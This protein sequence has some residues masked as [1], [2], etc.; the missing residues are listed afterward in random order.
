MAA[1]G[2]SIDTFS[3]GDNR[4]VLTLAVLLAVVTVVG[5]SCFLPAARPPG[6]LESF[7]LFESEDPANDDAVAE[8]GR[9]FTRIVSAK[10]NIWLFSDLN[11]DAGKSLP[12]NVATG[13]D[14]TEEIVKP[15]VAKLRSFLHDE[16]FRIPGA[17]N[18]D[19]DKL[20]QRVVALTSVAPGFDL[21]MRHQVPPMM[22][23][24]KYLLLISKTGQVRVAWYAFVSEKPMPG[25]ESGAFV[26]KMVSEDLNTERDPKSRTYSVLYYT[27]KSNREQ[28]MDN[29]VRKHVPQILKGIDKD[30]WSAYLRA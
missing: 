12:L 21:V 5:I 16:F 3:I 27:A 14:N 7:G 17:A 1:E 6:K 22:K 8:R 24:P 23:Q 15:C 2:D 11:R 13:G 25:V 10:N 30:D 29:V 19:L 9:D 4:Q 18:F 28:D 20:V 26:I